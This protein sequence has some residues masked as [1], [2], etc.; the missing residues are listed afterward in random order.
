MRNLHREMSAP[1][2]TP[3]PPVPTDNKARLDHKARRERPDCK[4]RK[5]LLV[6]KEQQGR[7]AIREQREQP[8]RKDP[9]ATQA[10]REL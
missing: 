4:V 9:R 7:R 5:A 1:K 2:V 6:R 10:L 8:G 3:A